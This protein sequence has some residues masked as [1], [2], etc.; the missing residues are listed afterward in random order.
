VL[1]VL[2]YGN[3]LRSD[4][5][6]GWQVAE[7]LGSA[8]GVEVA[9]V[10]QLV[11]E[12][13]T[14]VAGADGVLFLDAAVGCKPG[15]V[16]VCD[17]A[18]A[19]EDSGFGHI[20]HPA[21]LLDLTRRLDGRAPPAAIV[22]VTASHLGFGGELSPVVAAAVEP[23]REAAR[24]ALAR[25]A[26]RMPSTGSAPGGTGPA[27]RPAHGGAPVAGNVSLDARLRRGA[28]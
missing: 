11:P 5:G 18:P 26:T 24:S 2:A 12:L 14:L 21:G 1:L 4:D 25:L 8:P 3:P 13:A 17:L 9:C 7:A 19:E 10:H 6:V 27:P 15:C 22:T 20:L 23:A 28:R 16:T